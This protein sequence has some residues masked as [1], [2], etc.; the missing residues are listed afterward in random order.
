MGKP[1]FSFAIK[2]NPFSPSHII[3]TKEGVIRCIGDCKL[4]WPSI[5]V[6]PHAYVLGRHL[7]ET[8]SRNRLLAERSVAQIHMMAQK[9]RYDEVI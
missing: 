3:R 5:E 4:S 6:R 7:L 1:E 2:S 8:F 9:R